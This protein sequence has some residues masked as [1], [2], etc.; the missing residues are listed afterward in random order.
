MLRRVTMLLSTALV[1]GLLHAAIDGE[2]A[3]DTSGVPEITEE[4][5][6]STAEARGSGRPL[7][8]QPTSPPG[9]ERNPNE[10]PEQA[11]TP[12]TGRR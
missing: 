12:Q 1:M 7:P 10:R 6:T 8:G 2:Q 9:L 5:G 4:I 11:V 3:G